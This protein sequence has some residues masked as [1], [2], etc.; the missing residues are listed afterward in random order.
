ML[1]VAWG[2]QFDDRQ[3]GNP[4][5]PG[6]FA[7]PCVRKF[8]D[9]YYLYATPDGWGVGQG[10]FCIWTSKDFVHWSAHKSNWPT[11]D[12]KWAPSVVHA[13]GKY[14]L[15]TQVPCQVWVG[16]GD[17][18][19]GPWR[20]PLAGGGPM[21]PDQTPKGT[22]TLDGECFIDD[23]GQA[24]LMY[25]TW[26]TP[27]IVKL[28]R[29]LISWSEPPIQ[30]F[31]R[32]GAPAAS[33]GT[34]RGCMEAPFMLKHDGI[35]YYMYSDFYC[36]NSTY[37]VEY[38]TGKSP[39]GP[40]TYGTN[41]PILST[42]PDDSVDGP[43]HHTVLV[44]GDRTI[45]IYHR[46]DNPHSADGSH[47]Q[48]AA[49]VLRYGADG[50]LLKVIPTHAGVGY[51][52]PSTKRD[53]NWVVDNSLHVVAT[54]SSSGGPGFG[55]ENA[56][57]E[58]NG[59]LWKAS[60]YKY[61]QW[62]QIDLGR[63]EKVARV[64]TEFQFA[65]IAYRYKIEAS[66][67]GRNWFTFADRTGNF[68]WGPMIDPAKP[69]VKLR[70][71]KVVMLGDDAP[72]RP[73][74]EIGIWNVKIYDGVDKPNK[75][76][77]VDPGATRRC[78][79]A[80]AG[81]PLY[82]TVRDDGLPYGPVTSRWSKVSGPGSVTFDDPT[83]AE[84]T[85]RFGAPGIYTLRLTGDDGALRT[86]KDLKMVVDQTVPSK[87]V[88][89]SFEEAKGTRVIDTSGC[90]RDGF[91]AADGDV[92]RDPQRGSGAVGRA[93]AFDGA[94]S[95]VSVPPLGEQSSLTIAAWVKLNGLAGP[96]CV[97]SGNGDKPNTPRLVIRGDGR[98]AFEFAGAD[99]AEYASVFRFTDRTVGRWTHIAA[100]WDGQAKSLAFYVDGRLDCHKTCEVA[101]PATLRAGAR[102]GASDGKG[103]H[104]DGK[105]DELNVF[106]TALGTPDLA[107]LAR[108]P[109]ASTVRDARNAPI[110][111]SVT[112]TAVP[113]V[114]AP[115][116]DDEARGG[117]SFYIA[118]PDGSAA[119]KVVDSE[120]AQDDVVEDGGATLTGVVRIDPS[121]GGKVLE[122][123]SPP[124]NESAVKLEPAAADL[125]RVGIHPELEGKPLVVKAAVASIATDRK[126]MVLSA[127][128]GHT[129]AV[130]SE[131]DSIGRFI[132]PGN[133]VSVVGV[134]AKTGPSTIEFLA[135]SIDRISPPVQPDVLGLL[136]RLRFDEGAGDKAADSSGNDRT[137]AIHGATWAAEELGKCLS[138]DGRQAYVSIPEM[139]VHKAITITGWIRPRVLRPWQAIVH[140][141]VFAPNDVHLSLQEDGA[142]FLSVNGNEPVDVRSAP[143]FD[144][145]S[146]GAWR[147]FAVVYDSVAKSVK[148]YS[149]GKPIGT[150]HYSV[151]VRA[152]WKGGVAVGSW[153]GNDRFFDGEMR[154]LRF[155]GRALDDAEVARLAKP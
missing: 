52:A 17:T 152:G 105:I 96:G 115:R 132:A 83:N 103:E 151:A 141:D 146:V 107:L 101:G 39:L 137:G 131:S 120:S 128:G 80:F 61:P 26:W 48:I 20:N 12:F 54:A 72:E 108:A 76:P 125:A 69:A 53:T 134:P 149:D 10:R 43:G 22:I 123:T 66:A 36:A 79:F 122:L 18:P 86:S 124:E 41:N 81:V 145:S 98:I 67:D 93:L 70:F 139:G 28:N 113:V 127:E 5:I 154:D 114:Y 130:R 71:L 118:D 62:L 50:S 73:N 97:F 135:K 144:P 78:N 11:T 3:T 150:R 47:R 104:F 45:I 51:L 57:D 68:D 14:Y 87:I 23:D 85:A 100:V 63:S 21:I 4:L 148:F 140:T 19:L 59:T 90:C 153:G 30:F 9:T 55:P 121:T 29:D 42:S 1:S 94:S 44:D 16:V 88:S 65:Q 24:Y 99:G 133:V 138:F 27:T 8:G 119:M 116:N 91:L 77:F 106:R 13:N 95:Y 15:Y 92:K 31:A 102:I 109:N 7:D 49:D 129:L 32:Q 82:G 89:Y 142:L 35:Y 58:N 155:Y 112:L 117:G 126:S 111:R 84:T 75:A 46:H 37:C 25:G 33:R 64:E 136:S 56:A 147:H 6:Y 38:S 34:V 40:W 143:L 74:P 60:G 110:G 2:S